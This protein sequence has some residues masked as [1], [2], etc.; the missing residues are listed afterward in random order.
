MPNTQVTHSVGPNNARSESSVA[1]NPRHPRELVSG[2]KKFHNILTYDFTLATEYS[3]DGG[4]TW[5]DSAD[6][7]LPAGA[8]VMTDPTLA[9][10]D[11]GNV[12]L[13]GLTGNNPP[14]WDTIGIVI[15][16]S[17]DGG[18][19]WSAPNAIHNSSA[20]D[21]QWVAGD[22]SP[23]SPHHGN[24]YA[25]WDD[26]GGMDFARTTDHGATWT[27]AGG[28][29]AG[30]VI[31]T[32]SYYPEITVSD[33]GTV[34]IVSIGGSQIGMIVSTDGGNTFQ[35]APNP[36]SGVTTLE[37]SLPNIDGWAEFSPSGSFRV[38]TDPS[39]AAFGNTVVVAW[40]D[41][42]DGVSRIYHARSHDGGATWTTGASGKPLLKP[43]LPANFQHFHPQIVVSPHGV[44][45]CAFYEF[46]PKPA[47]MLIDVIVAQ[48]HD[49]GKSFHAHTVTDRPWN[50]ALD[51]PWAH[52]DPK[53]T[54]IGDYFGFATSEESFH[55]V[56]TDTRTG[57]Q[58][59]WTDTVSAHRHEDDD[60]DD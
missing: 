5:H 39:V 35:P 14:T 55:P 33:D 51:A 4:H 48:S 9:W 52:G 21:K 27:G 32:G 54:F 58:E 13:V 23:A 1:I 15:Y 2:S 10:D 41:Y 12:F 11:A 37:A 59:L 20:D 40:P 6:L 8:T 57:I 45:A 28:A 18:K 31:Q 56:W 3:H 26:V 46:G 47:N 38:I 34:Y 25:V 22:G 30:E 17:S 50:P 49:G 16:K 53:V 7:V 42:R 44:F 36:A 60:D 24:V 43:H 19:T 29:S